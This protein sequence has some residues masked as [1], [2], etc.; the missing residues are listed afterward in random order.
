MNPLDRLAQPEDDDPTMKATK[1]IRA[2]LADAGR[3]GGSRP[4]NFSKAELAKRRKRALA[5][6]KA[7]V[8]AAK[9]K[10]R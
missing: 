1:A 3:K 8:K 9:R 7:R 6:V 2:Y 5:M 4:K 10:S